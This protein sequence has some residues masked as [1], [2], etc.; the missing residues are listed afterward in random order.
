MHKPLPV[1]RRLEIDP[2]VF[3]VAEQLPKQV[4]GFILQRH[5]YLLR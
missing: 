5:P 1:D 4:G 2:V 3:A